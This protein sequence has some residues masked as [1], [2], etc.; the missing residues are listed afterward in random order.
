MLA[1]KMRN[2]AL[3]PVTFPFPTHLTFTPSEC[4]L[5]IGN[6]ICGIMAGAQQIETVLNLNEFLMRIL[7]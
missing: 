4:A 2:M 7:D 5:V 1:T 3:K 6:A